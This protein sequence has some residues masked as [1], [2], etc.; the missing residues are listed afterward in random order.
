MQK[1]ET[2]FIEYDRNMNRVSFSKDQDK[3]QF[4]MEVVP[5]PEGD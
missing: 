2:V 5:P 4:T 1:N 3:P